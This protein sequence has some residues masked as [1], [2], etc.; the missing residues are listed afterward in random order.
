MDRWEWTKI[1]ASVLCAVAVALGAYWFSGQLIGPLYPRLPAY[2]VSGVEEP[3]VD[4]AAL[5]RSWPEGLSAP[6][7][8]SRLRGYMGLVERGKVAMPVASAAAAV[9]PLQPP[10]DLGTLLASADPAKGRA[11]ARVCETCHSLDRGGPNRTGPD[12]WGVV[13]RP[14]ASHPGFA[15]SPAFAAQRG[16]WTYERLDQYLTSPARAVPGNKMAFAGLRRAEDRAGLLAFLG[17][18]NAQPAPFPAPKAKLAGR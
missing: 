10:A 8:E 12:L 3:P 1:A 13:G 7:D 17:S 18:L 6:G 5:Q 11:T 14:V 16:T 2:A 9:A 4:L 15:Y